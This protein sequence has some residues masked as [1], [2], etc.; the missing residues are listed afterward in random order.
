[1]FRALHHDVIHGVYRVWV[2]GIGVVP[3]LGDR[4]ASVLGGFE[5][6]FHLCPKP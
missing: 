4:S 6:L 3:R 2:H 5:L 1:M